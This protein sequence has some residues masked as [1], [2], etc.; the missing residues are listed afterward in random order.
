MDYSQ[1][2]SNILLGFQ[3]AR[4]DVLANRTRSILSISGVTIGV[5]T[6][7][8]SVGI[9]SGIFKAWRGYI[10][11]TG[12]LQRISVGIANINA[13]RRQPERIDIN[14]VAKLE[15][16]LGDVAVVS[17]VLYLWHAKLTHRKS[18]HSLDMMGV[19]RGY[20]DI[21]RFEVENGRLLSQWDNRQ[22]S[23][24][25]VIGYEAKLRLFGE[26]S[27]PV[28]QM[29]MVN[30][31][32]FT[33]VGVLKRYSYWSST[34]MFGDDGTELPLKNRFCFVPLA[35]AQ[36]LWRPE[37]DVV[38]ISVRQV[39]ELLA[40]KQRVQTMFRVWR[41]GQ[42]DITV[43]SREAELEKWERLETAAKMTVGM[44]A[45]LSLAVGG[46]G[47]FNVMIASLNERVREVGVRRALG[48]SRVDIVMQFL[49]EAV[50]LSLLGS[51]VG[52]LL[53]LVILPALKLILP[54][55]I[56]G[57]P[58]VIFSALIA[59]VCFGLVAGVIAGISPALK[60]G[61]LDPALALRCD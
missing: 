1:V 30:D 7:V 9:V 50:T 33:V 58:V 52:V 29:I 32:P 38:E 28:G 25:I 16:N 39:D 4:L 42:D 53:S 10:E 2:A 15:K 19:D 31:V 11:E 47:I 46:I 56:P 49:I 44:L 34:T 57:H 23:N 41:N 21:F 3:A 20:F 27:N 40:I 60:A 35:T 61:R 22:A 18:A 45:V 48:A 26:K 55:Q 51:I 13:Q 5:I 14:E 54:A 43:D 6:L 36:N 24:V 12:G 17:P 59:A 8:C 37:I